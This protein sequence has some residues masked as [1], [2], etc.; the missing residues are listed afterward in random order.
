MTDAMEPRP[1]ARKIRRRIGQRGSDLLNLCLYLAV[2]VLL[3][4]WIADAQAGVW[5]RVTAAGLCAAALFGAWQMVRRRFFPG[6]MPQPWLPA[7]LRW[8]R[9]VH[10]T[11]L[12]GGT[13]VFLGYGI[14]YFLAPR[15]FSRTV[16]WLVVVGYFVVI[17]MLSDFLKDREPGLAAMGTA[18]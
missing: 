18:E 10:A 1:P 2:S 3:L 7:R 17:S 15:R 9:T 5:A 11:V 4:T 16:S 12:V 8:L 14:G 6:L 13:V